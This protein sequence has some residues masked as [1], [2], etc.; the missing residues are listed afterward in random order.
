MNLRC[1]AAPPSSDSANTAPRPVATYSA[2]DPE[3]DSLTWSLG[4][5][6]EG[7]FELAAGVLSFLAP[8]DFESPA[9]LAGIN[10]Y[11]LSVAVSD[12]IH[13]TTLDLTVVVTDVDESGTVTTGPAVTG[14]PIIVRRRRRGWG[15]L[16]PDAQRGR[17]RVDREARHRR[18]R[19]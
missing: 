4:G 15:T 12:G 18:A 3:R 1:S 8:P 7:A 10:A 11:K 14:G 5:A 6:D 2:I 19:Q 9:N 17:L 13:T 16:R